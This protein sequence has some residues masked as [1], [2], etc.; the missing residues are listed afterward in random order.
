MALSD[1]SQTNQNPNLIPCPDCGHLI[2]K[3]FANSCPNCGST[4]HVAKK[5]VSYT[6]T[7]YIVAL[8]VG[9]G[10]TLVCCYYMGKDLV[11]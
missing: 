6:C 2:A 8:A 5:V 7:L 9:L 1:S 11:W 4:R 3:T 10:I